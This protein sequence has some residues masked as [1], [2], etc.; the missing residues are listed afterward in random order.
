MFGGLKVLVLHG[1]PESLAGWELAH[2]SFSAANDSVVLQWLRATDADVIAC[3][4]TWLPVLWS[5]GSDAAASYRRRILQG[6]SLCS[7]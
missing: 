1:D 7:E 4:H 3:T 5:A 2:E 6:T